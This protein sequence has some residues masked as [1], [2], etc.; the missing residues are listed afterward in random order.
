MGRKQRGKE[1]WPIVQGVLFD[2]CQNYHGNAD[3]SKAAH[4]AFPEGSKETLRVVVFRAISEKG[5]A[6]CDELEQRTGL[7]HQTCSA[8]ITELVIESK[9]IDTGRRRTTRAGRPARVYGV[10]KD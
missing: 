1:E 8:R 9:I 5:E 10:R 2:V 4:A 7:S 3:T 6:T